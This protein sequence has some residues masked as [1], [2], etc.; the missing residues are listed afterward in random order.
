DRTTLACARMPEWRVAPSEYGED[1]WRREH[2]DLK[3]AR[4]GFRC[5]IAGRCQREQVFV[6]N[7]KDFAVE[8]NHRTI[9]QRVEAAAISSLGLAVQPL[10]M[11]APDNRV[12]RCALL[13]A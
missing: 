11:E 13:L 10:G 6:A 4:G 8:R 5:R 2:V 7:G 9:R 1:R 12:R 3:I